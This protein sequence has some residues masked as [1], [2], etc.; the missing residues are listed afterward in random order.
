MEV[1]AGM[2]DG[3]F[4]KHPVSR[5]RKDAKGLIAA[6]HVVEILEVMRHRV[7]PPKNS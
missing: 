1:V 7:F 5:I 3:C 6:A 4:R 2:Q